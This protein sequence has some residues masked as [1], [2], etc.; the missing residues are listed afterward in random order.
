MDILIAISAMFMILCFV[1]A[2][3]IS[4]TYD[5]TNRTNNW[6]EQIMINQLSELRQELK[7]EMKPM[8]MKP[9]EI[10]PEMMMTISKPYVEVKTET[11]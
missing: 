3:A 4:M 6:S 8:E 10:K 7:S 2:V 9:M 1:I 11:K 5:Q